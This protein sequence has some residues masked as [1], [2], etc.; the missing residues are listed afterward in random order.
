[1][2]K[3]AVDK[4]QGRYFDSIEYRD[5]TH[6]V[7]A[8]YADPKIA[9][10]ERHISLEGRVLDL[11]CGNGI[12]TIR[13]AK[14]GNMVVGL[15]YSRPLLIHNPHRQL[16]QGDA[17]ALPF[18]DESFDC[19]F[20]ANLLHHISD[21][22]SAI[23]EMARTSRRYVVLVEPNRYNPLMFALALAVRAENGVL[24]SCVSRLRNELRNCGLRFLAGITTGMIS[25]NNTPAFL[26][27][28][29]RRFDRQIWWGEYIVLIGEKEAPYGTAT[30]PSKRRPRTPHHRP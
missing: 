23:R 20:E 21:R 3:S 22:E 29:L 28:L 9:F 30:T 25:Q 7:V 5:A 18:E 1:M 13:L 17:T 24:K 11:G 2:V 10:I 27:P 19:V 4:L 8:A 26:V 16:I 14:N 6:P 12:Y 15:D